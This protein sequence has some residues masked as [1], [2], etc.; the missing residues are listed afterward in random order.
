MQHISDLLLGGVTNR[1][2]DTVKLC[3]ATPETLMWSQHCFNQEIRTQ[4]STGCS[5]ES[6]SSTSVFPGQGSDSQKQSLNNLGLIKISS[7]KYSLKNTCVHV[8]NHTSPSSFPL[9]VWV[10]LPIPKSA[11][12]SCE[13]HIELLQSSQEWNLNSTGVNRFCKHHHYETRQVIA[14]LFY[15]SGGKK[16]FCEILSVFLHEN[17]QKEEFKSA[18]KSLV[19]STLWIHMKNQ[20]PLY[21]E[22]ESPLRNSA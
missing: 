6:Y 2:P 7:H 17:T 16:R 11:I 8:S 4:H 10:Q 3:S 21:S 1:K 9:E 22:K 12:P 5:E 18:F 13:R 19:Q 20:R 14:S 15:L